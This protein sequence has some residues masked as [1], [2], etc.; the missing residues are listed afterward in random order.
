MIYVYCMRMNHICLRVAF[1]WH[2]KTLQAWID[3]DVRNHLAARTTLNGHC[4][5][6]GFDARCA[7]NNTSNFNQTRNAFRLNQNELLV[8]LIFVYIFNYLCIIY[9]HV[10]NVCWIRIRF[11]K[12]LNILHFFFILWPRCC[13]LI[14]NFTC[15]FFENVQIFR[16]LFVQF[17]GQRI[18]ECRQI[19]QFNFQEVFSQQI[20]ALESI[21][22]EDNG[23]R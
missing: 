5:R 14:S 15:C 18:I 12:N 6:F 22:A 9:L 19:F 16:G 8:S 17:I 3:S 4:G 10:T 20:I 1:A 2:S 11:Q 13:D 7:N 21:S 23:Q